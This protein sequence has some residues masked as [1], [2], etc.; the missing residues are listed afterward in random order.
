MILYALDQPEFKDTSEKTKAIQ[1]LVLSSRVKAKLAL[2]QRTRGLELDAE[3]E[4][5][6]VFVKGQ[7]FTTVTPQAT[8]TQRTKAYITEIAKDIPGVKE[9]IV[10]FK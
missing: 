2:D 7:L 3:A 6:K 1:N 5:G 10:D 4:D 8:G 9:L